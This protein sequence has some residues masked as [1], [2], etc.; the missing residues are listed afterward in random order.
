MA[1]YGADEKLLVRRGA[2]VGSFKPKCVV[3]FSPVSGIAT[4]EHSF[5]VRYMDDTLIHAPELF[6]MAEPR[7][8]AS[9]A[10]PTLIVH[11][12]QDFTVPLDDSRRLISDLIEKKFE[13]RLLVVDG[14]GHSL[15]RSPAFD[16]AYD[17]A[18]DFLAAHLK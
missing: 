18:R 15:S 11:G 10:V 5:I 9:S 3:C 14:A 13:G 16:C 2:K 6:R 8:Y 1:G 4:N 7:T 17:A 12:T